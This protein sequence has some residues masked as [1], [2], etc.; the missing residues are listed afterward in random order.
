MNKAP[1]EAEHEAGE[2][3]RERHRQGGCRR[4]AYCCD[5]S[6]RAERRMDLARREGLVVGYGSLALQI[7]Y[8][9][10]DGPLA[11]LSAFLTVP[12]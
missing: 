1:G 8:A 9:L 6:A 11:W 12:D 10:H 3:E 7:R 5:R 2:T 4:H